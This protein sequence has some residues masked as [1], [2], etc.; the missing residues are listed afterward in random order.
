MAK[1]YCEETDEI[2]SYD[3]IVFNKRIT[4]CMTDNNYLGKLPW[5]DII[6]GAL[7]Y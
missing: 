3:D 2:F 5:N 6:S 7:V 4:K 1:F